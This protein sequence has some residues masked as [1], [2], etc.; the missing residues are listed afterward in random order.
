MTR[1]SLSSPYPPVFS[2]IGKCCP[3]ALLVLAMVTTTASAAFAAPAA[4]KTTLA[5]SATAVPYKTPI[6][7]TATVTSGGS[8]VTAGIV[9]FCEATAIF[10]ENNSAL[11]VA[12]LTFP[13]ATA[14]VKLGSGPIGTT[15]TKPYSEQT[16]AMR[17]AYRTLLH[18]Q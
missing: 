5:I 8:P 10:C 1:M 14:S 17:A 15:D 2:L 18:I 13:A 12:Q 6:T 11:G 4:T 7:L 9:L 3:K 16:T